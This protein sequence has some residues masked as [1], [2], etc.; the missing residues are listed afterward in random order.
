KIWES[1]GFHRMETQAGIHAFYQCFSSGL[2]QVLVMEGAISAIENYLLETMPY[3]SFQPVESTKNQVNPEALGEKTRYLLRRLF[4]EI[5]H[6]DTD[7]IDIEEPLES[8]GI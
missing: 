2:D 3:T 4:G 8:Y 7:R 1:M 5:I 6:V